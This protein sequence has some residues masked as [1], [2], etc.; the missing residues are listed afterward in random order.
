MKTV[1][2]NIYE[3]IVTCLKIIYKKLDIYVFYFVCLVF[4]MEL[5]FLAF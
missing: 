4:I 2:Q 5:R 1:F 3:K